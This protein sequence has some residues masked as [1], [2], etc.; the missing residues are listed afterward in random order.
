MNTPITDAAPNFPKTEPT[1]KAAP[2]D[3]IDFR[4]TVVFYMSP[5][6]GPVKLQRIKGK[7]WGFAYLNR[8]DLEPVFMGR[9]PVEAIRKVMA[10][11]RYPRF[12]RR[13][14]LFTCD[15]RTFG[16]MLAGEIQP[17]TVP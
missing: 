10:T 6:S 4:R 8:P 5:A 2:Y 14:V 11:R 12:N 16:R 15:I 7:T 1:M 9:S 17:P 3:K 13:R